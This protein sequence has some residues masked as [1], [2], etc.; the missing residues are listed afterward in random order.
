MT[1]NTDAWLSS[2]P[3]MPRGHGPQKLLIW[4]VMPTHHQ[5][6]FFAALR[7]AG[8]DVA[9]HYYDAVSSD[10]LRQGWD[11]CKQLPLNEQYVSQSASSL[12]LCAD[13][14]ER[15][16]ILPGYAKLF[17]VNIA[18]RLSL[19]R[20]QWLHWSEPSR[21]YARTL[22]GEAMRRFY[23]ALVNRYALGALAIGD[24]ARLDFHRWGIADERVRYLPYS[25]APLAPPHVANIDRSAQEGVR[26]LFIGAL[27][28]RKGID[29]L[30][31]AFALVY[32][33]FAD[34]QLELVGADEADGSYHRMAK[35]LG[36]GDSVKFLPAMAPTEIAK[37]IAACDVF[38]LA[39]RFDGWGVVLNEAASL[40][41]AIVATDAC[42]AAHHLVRDGENGYMVPAEDSAALAEAML[43]Y[44]YDKALIC[45]HGETSLE[46]FADVHPTRNAVRLA[47]ALQSLQTCDAATQ[48]ATFK[49]S[50]L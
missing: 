38:V 49:D 16:H 34:A 41:K 26:F 7:A 3:A 19:Q 46:L 6:G 47:Q 36:L 11:S 10:R 18:V 17:L 40:G 39:S 9:V 28:R 5:A 8:F 50:P 33:Y 42:G 20:V 13:W 29:V 4:T 35:E 45:K 48:Q 2:S 30:L 44:C 15:I 24:M 12:S 14:R 22:R 27:C 43:L 31:R 23:G 32:S 1:S 37:P 21:P 25:V